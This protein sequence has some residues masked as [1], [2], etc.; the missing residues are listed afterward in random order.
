MKKFTNDQPQL[1][2]RHSTQVTD[3]GSR[4]CSLR[5]TAYKLPIIIYYLIQS[6][7]ISD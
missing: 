4:Q 3:C 5:A 2:R 6:V 7:V 1:Q